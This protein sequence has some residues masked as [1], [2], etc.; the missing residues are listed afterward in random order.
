MNVDH[1]Y[2]ED[3]MLIDCGTC[4]MANIACGDCVVTVLLGTPDDGHLGNEEQRALGVLADAGLVPAL[5]LVTPESGE[6]SSPGGESG[7]MA[8]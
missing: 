1:S 5:R 6:S 7:R 4:T 2:L 3:V 8:G